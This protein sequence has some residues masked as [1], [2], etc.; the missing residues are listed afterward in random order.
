MSYARSAA[1]LVA[2][3]LLFGY[4]ACIRAATSKS[5]IVQSVSIDE[6]ERPN[7][8][9]ETNIFPETQFAA[10][11][12]TARRLQAERPSH[13]VRL[14]RFLEDAAA[15]GTVVLDTRSKSAFDAIHLA[16]AINV[17]F[18]DL[19]AESVAAV[20]PSKDT[21]VLIYCNNN[22]EITEEAAIA[23]LGAKILAHALNIPTH[24]T[25]ARLGYDNVGELSESVAVDDS[26]LSWEGVNATN[27]DLVRSSHFGPRS[28]RLP[29]G[30]SP[31]GP[32]VP[33]VPARPKVVP[34]LVDF[35]KFVREAERAVETNLFSDI[36]GPVADV[37]RFDP[38]SD[39][40]FAAV[41]D[42]DAVHVNFSD[43]TESKLRTALPSTATP[44]LVVNTDAGGITALGPLTVLTL[45]GYGYESV[46]LARSTE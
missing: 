10:F 9:P 20:V 25:L 11:L 18:A 31:I 8:T 29:D 28:V 21:R 2:V 15:P 46:S 7:A 44:I 30:Q 5:V 43:F 39:V 19:S 6:A 41:P 32:V 22:F 4:A 17:E 40:A 36:G 27:L 26:R 23:E 3:V 12:S 35:D 33:P 16:G 38:R 42:G 13:L 24:T 37:V 34:A 14:D 1:P 45:R